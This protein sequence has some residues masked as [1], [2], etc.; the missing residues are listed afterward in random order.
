MKRIILTLFLCWPLWAIADDPL[1]RGKFINPITDICWS[2]TLP[3]SIGGV[4]VYRSSQED[5]ANPSGVACTCTNPPTV[6]VKFGFWEASRRIDITRSPYCMVSLGTSFDFGISAPTGE[7]KQHPEDLTK[8][9]FYQAHWYI[10]PLFA[11]LGIVTDNPCLEVKAFDI[12]Y[13]TEIDPTWN[14]D[15]LTL[16]LNPE[17]FLFSNPVTQAACAADCVAANADFGLNSLFWCAGCNGSIY[18]FNGRVQAHI[19]GYQASALIAQRFTAKMHREGLM[20]GKT[21]NEGLCGLYLN[22][23][24]K[25]EQYKFQMLYPVAQTEKIDG[26]CCQPFGRTTSI[27]G[28]GKEIP[29]LEDFAIELFSKRTCCLG[30]N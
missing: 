17:V 26:K 4:N 9:S 15:E 5:S 8:T 11:I 14:E 1:C 12:A 2:C 21:G 29:Y 30:F 27:Y 22:P 20:Y 16:L 3:I 6:G 7:V 10:D 18:P 19:S 23:V 13:M 28:A 25:K 24:M